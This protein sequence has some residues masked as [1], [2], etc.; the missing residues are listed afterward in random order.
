MTA[1]LYRGEKEYD[2]DRKEKSQ[3]KRQA[4]STNHSSMASQQRNGTGY[5]VEY[6]EKLL[7]D[8]NLEAETLELVNVMLNKNW[9]L[10]QLKSAEV[11][12]FK[13][14]KRLLKLKIFGMHPPEG[15]P[16]QGEYR[17]FIFDDQGD[18]LSPLSQRQRNE[19]D[20]LL[21]T[22]F[23]QDTRSRDGWQQE[24]IGKTTQVSEY[25]D[26]SKSESKGLFS[27]R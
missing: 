17:K 15:S 19:I 6:L 7:D 14:L 9:V 22:V 24:Q 10:S 20:Q 16:I 1:R 2:F 25:K 23:A 21:M 3:L 4:H 11:E 27:F 5:T 26:N 8:D 13:W 18:A 12:E